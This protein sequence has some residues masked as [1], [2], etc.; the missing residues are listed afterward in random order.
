MSNNSTLISIL[1]SILIA[2][3]LIILII[4]GL[5]PSTLILLAIIAGLSV[6]GIVFSAILGMSQLHFRGHYALAV[7]QLNASIGGFVAS[8]FALI[9]SVP[10]VIALILTFLSIFFGSLLLITVF[11]IIRTMLN[12]NHI[13]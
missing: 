13:C 12:L 11:V 6:L 9:L 7:Q 4:L 8:L 2:V 10:T 5:L 3:G 1:L